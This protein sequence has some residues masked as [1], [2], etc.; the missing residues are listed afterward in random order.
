MG[1]LLLFVYGD[2]AGDIGDTDGGID[3]IDGD[4]A[5]DGGIDGGDGTD[6]GGVVICDELDVSFWGFERRL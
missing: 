1:G 6:G 3:S 2:I 4:G 5:I